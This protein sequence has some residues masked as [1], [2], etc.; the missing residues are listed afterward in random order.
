MVVV[1]LM[2]KHGL[3]EKEV[4]VLFVIIDLLLLYLIQELQ[5]H[6]NILH[7]PEKVEQNA[8]LLMVFY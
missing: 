4:V 3:L 5:A 2:P 8:Y 7:I 1:L 6:G